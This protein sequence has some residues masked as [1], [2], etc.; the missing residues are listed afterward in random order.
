MTE[1]P[2]GA[3]PPSSCRVVAHP[4]WDDRSSSRAQHR[5]PPAPSSWLGTKA[6]S[7]CADLP[8]SSEAFVDG[9]EV[10]EPIAEG[11][12]PHDPASQSVR[13]VLVVLRAPVLTEV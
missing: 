5:L 8:R 7:T 2:R 12:V 1:H 11:S 3:R 13:V 4:R 10:E 6:R 9:V